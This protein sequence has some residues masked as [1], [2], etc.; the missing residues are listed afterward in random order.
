[1]IRLLI[2]TLIYILANALGLLVA[3]LLLPGFNIS[4]IAFV[5]ATLIFTAIEVVVEPLFLKISI[6]NLPKMRG[7][8]ALVTT[9]LG[10]YLTSLYVD[11]MEIGGVA[12]W[13]A[14]TLIVWLGALIATMV[15]PM[16]VFKSVLQNRKRD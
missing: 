6:K 12:N 2:S 7:G 1:M 10:L 9:F 13:L 3:I 14:A 16:V 5:W 8:V 15:L 11:G 4:P